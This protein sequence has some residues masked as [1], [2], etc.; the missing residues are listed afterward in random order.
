L[1]VFSIVPLSLNEW[2]LVFAFAFP[3]IILDE[4]L[5]FL[6]R[7]FFGV[8]HVVAKPRR[9]SQETGRPKIA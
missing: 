1:Q 9:R 8:K 4:M 7:H 3:V 5:K 6:G 2:A